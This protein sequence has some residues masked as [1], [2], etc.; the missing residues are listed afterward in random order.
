M[1]ARRAN[2]RRDIG[3]FRFSSMRLSAFVV[4]LVGFVP[5]SRGR[6]DR[7]EYGTR[8][9][10]EARRRRLL[11]PSWGVNEGGDVVCAKLNSSRLVGSDVVFSPGLR[12]VAP[13]PG[14]LRKN[15]IP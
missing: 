3:V 5:C 8:H 12:F 9:S 15:R 6:P 11:N 4:L 7:F 14:V 2:S 13:P 1:A 10:A